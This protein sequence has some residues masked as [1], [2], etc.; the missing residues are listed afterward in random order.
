MKLIN[1]LCLNLFTILFINAQA[2]QPTIIIPKGFKNFKTENEYNLKT[3]AEFALKKQQLSYVHQDS[4]TPNQLDNL[5]NYLKIDIDDQSNSFN[6]KLKIV[7]K[8][9]KE[10]IVLASAMAKSKEKTFQKSYTNAFREAEKTI[11]YNK[12]KSM[13]NKNQQAVKLAEIKTETSQNSPTNSPVASPS[14][15]PITYKIKKTNSG[16]KLTDANEMVTY[17]FITSTQNIYTYLYNG[18]PSLIYQ[19]NNQW[20]LEYFDENQINTKP[21]NMLVE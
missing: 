19:V 11:D 10:T 13:T 7:F 3:L 21:L 14:S 20:F 9:C 5:C 16:F 2:F 18:K 1:I 8:D 15:K 17:M 12:L 6:V 4:L